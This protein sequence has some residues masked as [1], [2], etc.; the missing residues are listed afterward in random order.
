MVA[1]A[2][3][4]PLALLAVLAVAEVAL[5]ALV[6]LE[7]LGKEIMAVLRQVVATAVVVV[8]RV[9]LEVQPLEQAAMAQHPL[10]Q[11]QALIT[12]GAVAVAM[13]LL[14]IPLAV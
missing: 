6:A 1:E 9:Q 7:L 11:A 4:T 2:D 3:T 10:L 13:A 14:A 8:E 12:R 5:V